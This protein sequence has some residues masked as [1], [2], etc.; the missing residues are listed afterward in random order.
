L[1][2]QSIGPGRDQEIAT[3]RAFEERPLP[4]AQVKCLL[5]LGRFTGSLCAEEDERRIG[6]NYGPLLR[7]Q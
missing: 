7:A 6:C 2:G 3:S 4:R 5:Q 1:H